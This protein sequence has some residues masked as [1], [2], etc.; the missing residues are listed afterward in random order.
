MQLRFKPSG[1]FPGNNLVEYVLPI[2]LLF[3]MGLLIWNNT[4]VGAV[5]NITSS[6]IKGNLQGN[7]IQVVPMG[8]LEQTPNGVPQ[9]FGGEIETGSEQLCFLDSN[10][11]LN[12]PIIAPDTVGGIGSDGVD[13]LAKVLEQLP[14]ILEAKGTD[15]SVVDMV[16]KLANLGH[17]LG[18]R[19]KSLEGMCD[20][21]GTCS[22]SNAQKAKDLLAE[23]KQG[24][25]NT[26]LAE[27]TALQE[28][29][30]ANPE[31]L[32]GFPE[33]YGIIE[34]K[35][36]DINTLVASISAQESFKRTQKQVP[37]GSR[38][39]PFNIVRQN[40]LDGI[41]FSNASVP[42]IHQNANDVCSQGGRRCT[43]R[44]SDNQDFRPDTE[45]G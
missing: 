26:F 9:V 36:N 27:W 4:M 6:A 7:T 17:S 1:K 29:M 40:T 18:E 14:P 45:E 24:D 37:T 10:T 21:G 30:G 33:A 42:K 15:P 22:T 2:A 3:G 19:L 12:I 38:F 41:T 16:S 43:W 28:K 39:Q 32:A 34:K 31:A 35:V 8:T 13:K 25:L 20:S 11:C 44:T 5:Q 23:I